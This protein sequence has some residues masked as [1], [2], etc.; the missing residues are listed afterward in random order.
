MY[1]RVADVPC[2][3]WDQCVTPE[4][5]VQHLQVLQRTAHVLPLGQTLNSPGA[6]KSPPRTVTL[7][8]D[9][10]YVDNLLA[11][12]PLLEQ[13][14]FPATFFLATGALGQP[15]EFWWDELERL[16]LHPGIL[17]ECLELEINGERR[18]WFLGAENVY[19]A[20]AWEQHRHWR[21]RQAPTTARQRV[22]YEVWALL[23]PLPVLV[24]ERILDELA[25]WSGSPRVARSTHRILTVEEARSLGDSTR[26]E[27]GAHTINH[28]ALSAQPRSVQEQE[29]QSGKTDVESIANRQTR[30]FAYPYGDYS[31]ETTAI[32]RNS[33]FA[34]AVTSDAACLHPHSNAWR[35]PRFAVF[36]CDG[37]TFARR[38][39]AMFESK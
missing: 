6:R 29:I 30:F 31:A 35:L 23:R 11:A 19:S 4:H 22:F 16:L 27:L 9:D 28:V 34:S 12:R 13:H 36:D 39:S 8:F 2:D 37:E 25:A 14:G 24:Q 15:K 32:V 18:K 21:A 1:H 26:F 3:P 10:G 20:D 38:L 17:P 33:G 7:T 5:F